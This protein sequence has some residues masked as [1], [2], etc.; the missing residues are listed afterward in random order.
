MRAL[1]F[2]LLA[3]GLGIGAWVR[4]CDVPPVSAQELAKDHA[5]LQGTWVYHEPQ[6]DVPLEGD[7]FHGGRFRFD[8]TIK[9]DRAM[10]TV[11]V[12]ALHV[13]EAEMKLDGTFGLR[14][15]RLKWR[16]QDLKLWQTP[17]EYLASQWEYVLEGDVLVVTY[18]DK[19]SKPTTKRLLREKPAAPGK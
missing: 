15:M 11:G 17:P 12:C 5:K 19:D 14:T 18:R 13:H 16:E 8:V 2:G 6:Q 3:V 7:P 4:A 9:G 1:C 10:L